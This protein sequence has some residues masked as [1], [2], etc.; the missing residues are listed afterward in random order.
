MEK[1]TFTHAVAKKAAGEKKQ[2]LVGV[3]ASGNLEVL[4]ERDLPDDKCTVKVST[5]AHGFGEVWQSVVAD[6]IAR[7][8]PGGLKFSINDGGARPDTVML[9]LMQA[10]YA[11]EKDA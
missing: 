5:A 8:S 4:G 9:R 11:L 6:F 3:V 10:A 7:A 1:F 2:V